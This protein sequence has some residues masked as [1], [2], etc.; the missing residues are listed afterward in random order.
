LDA[1]K[2]GGIGLTIVLIIA[3]VWWRMS[4]RADDSAFIK[5]EAL[6]VVALMEG[7]EK[8]KVLLDQMAERAHTAAFD[9]AYEMGRRR[10]GTTFD[11]DKYLDAF[12]RSMAMQADMM[13]RPDLK[14]A[15]ANLRA[16]GDEEAPAESET[17]GE[18]RV[19][20]TANALTGV[21]V[22]VESDAPP[23]PVKTGD[24]ASAWMTRADFDAVS[25]DQLEGMLWEH[26]SQSVESSSDGE[27]AAVKELSKGERM[28]YVT[29]GVEV[30]VNNGGF[31]Q[32]F[33]NSSGG[34]TKMAV[35]AFKLVGAKKYATVMRRAIAAYARTNP[36]QKIF[37]VDK[38]VKG[39]LKKYKDKSVDKVD[40]AFYAVKEDLR[41]LRVK[42]IRDNP[43]E[44]ID[45]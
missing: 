15:L 43:D 22:P 34:L 6:K 36:K 33:T 20:G 9:K 38:T 25:D 29:L 19:A 2:L 26:I 45:Q 13:S 41:A 39:Y 44:F 23:E 17:S 21:D 27:V 1:K 37:K 11:E 5:A 10:R 18:D 35:P 31:D 24:A 4:N 7:Y 12:F 42:Y 16:L 40:D 8:D 28:L 32:F 14:V 3:V 30:E